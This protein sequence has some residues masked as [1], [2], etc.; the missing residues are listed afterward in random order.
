MKSVKWL[1]IALAT[2][3]ALTGCAS[4]NQQSASPNTNTSQKVTINFI[5]GFTGGD[6]VFM[7]KITDGFNQSQ[8]K[9]VIKETQDKD[10]YTKF[11]T[12]NYDLVVIHTVNLKTYKDDG[13]IQEVTPIMDKAGIKASDFDPAGVNVATVDGKMYALPLDIHPLTMLYNKDLVSQ[14]PATYAD[15]VKLQSQLKAKDPN[16]YALGV[17]SSGL[18]EFYIMTMAAQNGI[19]LL[20]DNYLNFAQPELADA[21]LSF[22]KMIYKDKI[23]PAGLGLD[24]EFQ[25]F[26]KSAKDSNA[27]VQ[28]AVALT[29]PWFYSAAKEKYGDKLGVA[30]IPVL[31]KQ[32]AVYGNAHTIAVSA[33]VKDQKVLDGI[34]EFYKYLYTPQNLIHWAESGQAPVH[35][36]TM[37]YI[38]AHKDQYPLSYV[39]EQQFKSF[40]TPVRVYQYGEQIRYMNETVFAKVVS[41]PNITKDDIMKELQ[42][43]T[44]KAKQIAATHP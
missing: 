14:P 10:H 36:A 3:L 22:N 24:G 40:A 6:G 43:A 38:A 32:A 20:K 13:M 17:P 15:L 19:N 12:G 23:S 39:N 31:G 33:K 34:A 21:L 42:T 5:N 35:K 41:N 11:K 25:T 8:D 28:S 2:S 4:K 9:Y 44:D 30:P 26:M 16:L 27:A 29:G 37:D 18:V 1:S 7:K